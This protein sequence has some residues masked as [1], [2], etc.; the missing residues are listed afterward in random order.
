HTPGGA[1]WGWES[2]ANGKCLNMFYADSLTAVSADKYRFKSNPEVLQDFESSFKRV[3]AA[4]C[5][6]LLTPHP[7]LSQMFE[8]LDPA[9]GSRA[10]D[11]KDAT[12]CQRYAKA[13]REALAKRLADEG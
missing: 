1:S 3:A 13:A 2:C 12:A 5:D 10:A 6:V 7:D 11:I 4:P 9:T 8:R